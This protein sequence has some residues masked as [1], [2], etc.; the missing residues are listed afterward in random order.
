MTTTHSIPPLRDFIARRFAARSPFWSWLVFERAGGAL[1]YLL[2]RL[3]V[4]PNVVTLL[5][6]VLGIAGAVVLGTADG[7]S[8]V[9]AAAVLLSLAYALD[10]ADGQLARAT[11]RTS[12]AGALLDVSVDALVTVFL[13]T[14]LAFAL[15]TA[16]ESTVSDLLLAG[17]F[18][19]CRIT[20]LMASIRIKEVTRRRTESSG[21]RHVVQTVYGSLVETPFVYLALSA[22]RLLPG[23]FEGVIAVIAV[24]TVG[25]TTVSLR[26]HSRTSATGD[27]QVT[28]G[29]GRW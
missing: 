23:V 8:D 28:A 19:A 7:V 12:D 16:G 3:G 20:A 2:G 21:V 17:A 15:T 4:T 13:T 6:G 5:G 24:L 14:A 18:G 29:R 27:R 1:A 26:R 10:C 9:L 25:R 11:G 22:T